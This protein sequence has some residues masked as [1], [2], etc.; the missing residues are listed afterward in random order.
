VS[1][2]LFSSMS[3]FLGFGALPPESVARDV[4]G[5]GSSLPLDAAAIRATFRWQVKRL[6]PDLGDAGADG[7]TRSDVDGDATAARLEALLWARDD[8][9][10]RARKAELAGSVTVGVSPAGGTGGSRNAKPRPLVTDRLSATRSALSSR[11]AALLALVD[12]EFERCKR[13]GLLE[14]SHRWKGKSEAELFTA[15]AKDARL[16]CVDCAEPLEGAIYLVR[17]RDRQTVVGNGRRG[18]C[19]SCHAERA[20]QA[21]E[22]RW[23]IVISEARRCR[24]GTEIYCTGDTYDSQ[25]W[26]WAKASETCSPLC[27]REQANADARDRRRE[28]RAGRTCA[29]CGEEFEPTRA[30]ARYCSSACRQDAYRK[31]KLGADPS[32]NGAR[33]RPRRPGRA[34]GPDRDPMATE[35]SRA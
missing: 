32:Q 23:P 33:A 35:I 28:L 7:L 17:D 21:D 29:V 9:L 18:R 22:K 2:H 14:S 12:R 27:A 16:V 1:D 8:L 10:E 19:A 5:I 20:R 34:A 30:D 25:S 13:W 15:L 26:W 3:E 4:L 24:C 11:N 6:R 31:R